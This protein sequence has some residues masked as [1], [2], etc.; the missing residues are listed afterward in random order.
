MNLFVTVEIH[1]RDFRR[2]THSQVIRAIWHYNPNGG[3]GQFHDYDASE[4]N[5]K[6]C[7]K[8]GCDEKAN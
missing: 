5:C 7:K 6:V 2:V 8:K 3:H 1:Y 4:R